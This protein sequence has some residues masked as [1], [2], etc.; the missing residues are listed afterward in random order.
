MYMICGLGNPGRLYEKTRHNM[1][2]VTIDILSDKFNIPLNKLKFKALYGE[3]TIGGE[4]VILVKPQTYMNLSGEAVRPLVDYFK[5]PMDKL[6]VV[7]DD[8]DLPLGRT[9]VRRGG[10][11]GT[12]NGMR[13]VIYQLQKDDFARVRIGLGPHGD[14]PLDRFVIGR[15]TDE[16]RPVLGMAC[17]RAADAC[18]A[19]VEHGVEEA[20]Q[21]FNGLP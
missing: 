5:I 18:A 13:S 10:S 17:L 7:Y 14:I 3:G 16:E 2:F 1:G 6:L 9:R 21:R 12:H 8:I 4:K 15:W 20:M 11:A 19:F